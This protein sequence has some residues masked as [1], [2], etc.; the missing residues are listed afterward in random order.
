MELMALPSWSIANLKAIATPLKEFLTDDTYEITFK[1][2]EAWKQR[3]SVTEIKSKTADEI[4]SIICHFPRA[5]LSA[6][7]QRHCVRWNVLSRPRKAQTDD[8]SV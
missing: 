5:K 6:S 3:E 7:D 1:A 8:D 2:V 4:A